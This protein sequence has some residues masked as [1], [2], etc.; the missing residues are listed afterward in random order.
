[1]TLSS[2]LNTS[3]TGLN[4]AQEGIS[5]SSN[6][7][8]NVDTPG[9][10]K[11]ETKQE[12]LITGGVG[13]GAKITG[14]VAN[15]DAQLLKSIQAQT[16][17]SGMANA[18]S[19][20]YTKAQTLYGQ[21]NSGNGLSDKIDKFFT[22][23]QSL[24]ENPETVSLR[25]TAVNSVKSLADNISNLARELQQ[26][27]LDSDRQ[28]ERDIT[29]VNSLIDNLQNTNSNI[30]QFPEGSTGRISVEQDRELNLRK[31]SEYIDI[32]TTVDIKGILSVSTTSGVPLLEGPNK[33]Q[34][35]HTTASS[36]ND[37]INNLSMTAIKAIALRGDG[38]LSDTATEIS[39][40]GVGSNVT[41]T[42][43]GGTIKGLLDLRDVDLPRLIE[44]LDNLASSFRDAVN[45]V[46]N[47]GVSFPPPSSLTGTKTVSATDEFGF[48]GK[49]M[50]AVVNTD[51]TSIASPYSDET[52][53]RPLTLDLSTLDSGNGAGRPTMQTIVDEINDYFGPVQTRATVGNLRDIRL[54]AVSD[55]ISDAG[56]AQFDLQLDNTSTKSSTIVVNSATVID[57]NDLTQTY[58]AATLPNPNTFTI[59]AG[60]RGR[61]N[62]P[63]TLDFSG[64]NNRASYTVR[65]NVTITDADG[66]ISTADI[67]YTIADNVT[68]IRNDKYS[69]NAVS[70]VA[71][72]GQFIASPSSISYA[73]ASIVN[74]DGDPVSAG[75]EGFLKITTTSGRNF[76]IAIDEMDS[77]ET[78]LPSTTTANITNKGFSAYFELN[79]L[80][81]SHDTVAGSAIN[82][83]VRSDILAN[84]GLLSR[85][86]LVLSSQPHDTSTALYTYELGSGN[87]KNLIAMASLN[88]S[89]IT[90]AAAGGLP[91][92]STTFNG[93]SSDMIGFVATTSLSKSSSKDAEAIGL[94]GLSEL[95]Q[96]SSGVKTDDELGK[97]IELQNNFTASAKVIGIIQELFR[98]LQQVF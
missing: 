12:S 8:A 33:Y 28:I 81:V 18:L 22:S 85:G 96:K 97:I 87:N 25:L 55:S 54:A 82:M 63:L 43:T 91:L 78:G 35:D 94:Q 77:Q 59:A 26:L 68:D 27:R 62:I 75:Q 60:E 17:E 58:N 42:L 4:V 66:N 41:T 84:T 52:G 16:S 34:V 47:D 45:A 37:F 86:A 14:I 19:E 56:T 7:I 32:S 80:F 10:I 92:T 21:P 38:S 70:N 57:P 44:Q 39:S 31:L 64:D 76:G 1:M 90:F 67:D 2:A 71:G 46:H 51:G 29:Q 61:T 95:L 74:E 15:V 9:Y 93:Y 48:T 11:Q 13:Q 65:L 79:N 3:L 89:D 98:I 49:V 73:H 53:F 5:V 30:S 69:A 6:N 83:E 36:I 72:T 24:S 50:I 88:N 20:F 23:F 40:S